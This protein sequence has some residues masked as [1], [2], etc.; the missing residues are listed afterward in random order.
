MR[1]SCATIFCYYTFHVRPPDGCSRALLAQHPAHDQAAF[2]LPAFLLLSV[3][4]VVYN[5]IRSFA[6][7]DY[8][9]LHFQRVLHVFFKIFLSLYPLFFRQIFTFFIFSSKFTENS[10][11]KRPKTHFGHSIHLTLFPALVYDKV[12]VK[13]VLSESRA[14]V[15]VAF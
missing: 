14:H 15:R 12:D 9:N 2:L 3:S 7:D 4:L 10:R 6:S 5:E 1:L 11:K 8:K 13:L